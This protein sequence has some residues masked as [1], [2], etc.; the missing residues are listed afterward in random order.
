MSSTSNKKWFNGAIGTII[1]SLIAAIIY[2][3][4]KEQPIL[5]TI[6]T[7]SNN[8]WRFIKNL[9]SVEIQLWLIISLLLLY[10]IIKWFYIKVQKSKIPELPENLKNYKADDFKNWKWKWDWKWDSNKAKWKIINLW[11]FCKK[12]DIELLDK[13]NFIQSAMKCPKCEQYFQESKIDDSK[14]VESMIYDNIQK[15]RI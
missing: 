4:I 12:C 8:I 3:Y 2:D 7:I 6:T 14:G 11:P 1:L 13:S 9:F 5:S 15:G 10:K